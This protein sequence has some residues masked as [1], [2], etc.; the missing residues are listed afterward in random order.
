MFS[1]LFPWNFSDFHDLQC[2]SSIFSHGIYC[3]HMQRSKFCIKTRQIGGKYNKTNHTAKALV[4]LVFF[5]L[6]C[7]VGE[8]A[9][10]GCVAN[11]LLALVTDDQNTWHATHDM[12]HV[13]CDNINIKLPKYFGFI[14]IGVTIRTCREK[15][16][17]SHLR[18]LK[19]KFNCTGTAFHIT[20]YHRPSEKPRSSLLFYSD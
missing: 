5:Y 3:L 4:E 18:F 15:Q 17:L 13:T 10:V 2:I 7:I 9:G 8:L 19:G 6:L 12:W 20:S 14:G 16:C 11:R 1:L